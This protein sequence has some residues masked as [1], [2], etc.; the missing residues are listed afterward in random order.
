VIVVTQQYH[1]YRALYVA[2]D[3]GIEA[4]GSPSDLRAYYGIRYCMARELLARCKD[5]LFCLINFAPALPA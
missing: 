4:V 3:M 5:F 2:Q 1:L